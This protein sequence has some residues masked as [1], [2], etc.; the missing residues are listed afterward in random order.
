MERTH[1]RTAAAAALLMAF[2]CYQ[3]SSLPASAAENGKWRGIFCV[4]SESGHVR[5]EK[6]KKKSAAL[7]AEGERGKE[8]SSTMARGG[9]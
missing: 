9:N 4:I 8:K 5:P 3:L 1:E 6:K 2:V 7:S